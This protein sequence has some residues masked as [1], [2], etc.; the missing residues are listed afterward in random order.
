MFCP[1]TY[2]KGL[3]NHDASLRADIREENHTEEL[4]KAHWDGFQTV[5]ANSLLSQKWLTYR[6]KET[7]P[8]G[9]VWPQQESGDGN[10]TVLHKWLQHKQNSSLVRVWN[11]QSS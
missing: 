11:V 1:W 10:D 8:W 9:G 2:Y 3:K 7:R 6:T 4:A 5:Y